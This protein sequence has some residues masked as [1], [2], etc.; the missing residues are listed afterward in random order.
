[1]QVKCLTAKKKHAESPQMQSL[2]PQKQ[3]AKSAIESALDFVLPLRLEQEEQEEMNAVEL[4]FMKL[5]QNQDPLV[6]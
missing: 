5:M 3:E 2:R 6:D 4:F 1:M